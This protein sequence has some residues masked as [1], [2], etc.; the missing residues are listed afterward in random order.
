MRATINDGV[1]RTASH[2]QITDLITYIS[3]LPSNIPS[4]SFPLS[5]TREIPAKQENQVFREKLAHQWVSS[6]SFLY[7]FKRSNKDWKSISPLKK[8]FPLPTFFFFFT[9]LS[10]LDLLLTAFYSRV[11]EE[12]EEKRERVVRLVQVDLLAPRVPPEMMVLKAAQYVLF[13]NHLMKVYFIWQV[14]LNLREKKLMQ[15]L[16]VFR[17]QVVSLE[18]PALLESLVLLYV[19]HNLWSVQTLFFMVCFWV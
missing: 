19:W 4:L 14:S 9:S 1:F 5:L 13:C 10:V 11:Q 17:V 15:L 12:N 7:F 8:S 3:V 6:F 16:L 2:Q 18:I